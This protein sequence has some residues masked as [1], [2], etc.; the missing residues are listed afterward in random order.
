MTIDLNCQSVDVYAYEIV[1]VC[2]YPVF[3]VIHTMIPIIVNEI[4]RKANASFA[5]KKCVKREGMFVMHTESVGDTHR[6]KLLLPSH[7]HL[8]C[9]N[10]RIM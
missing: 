6:F 1:S 2:L 4:A 10:S 8:V 3:T 7:Y 9:A 5:S